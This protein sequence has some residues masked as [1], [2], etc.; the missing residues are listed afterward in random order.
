VPVIDAPAPP[1]RPAKAAGS[2]SRHRR[3]ILAVVAPLATLGVLTALVG[4]VILA[5]PVRSPLQDC[6]TAFGFLMDGRTDVYGDPANPPQGATAADVEAANAR[7]CRPRVADRGRPAAVAILGGLIVATTAAA[8]EVGVR[9]RRS[10]H[11]Q[12]SRP[13]SDQGPA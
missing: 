6:G 12:R 10:R 11:R 1:S 3:D 2:R 7:P 4:V 9:W 13:G 8:T 5:L